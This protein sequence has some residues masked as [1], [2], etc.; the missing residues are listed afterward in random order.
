LT[1]SV[2][3]I[4]PAH[5]NRLME[6]ALQSERLLLL[7][8]GV[9]SIRFRPVLDVAEADIDLMLEKLGRCL[10]RLAE[11][12]SSEPSVDIARQR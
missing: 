9:Q 3:S 5:R 2:F 4:G 6:I 10:E 12:S 7:G 1:V 8:A 11:E